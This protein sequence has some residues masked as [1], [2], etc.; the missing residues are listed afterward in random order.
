MLV[1]AWDTRTG[2][3]LPN[4]VPKAWLQKKLFPHLVGSEA[5]LKKSTEAAT[6]A[7]TKKGA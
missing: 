6:A 3:K 2:Q 4:D 7:A 5:D 1:P